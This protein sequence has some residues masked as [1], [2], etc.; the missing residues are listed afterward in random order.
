MTGYDRRLKHPSWVS[1]SL[2]FHIA[3]LICYMI[4]QTAQHLTAQNLRRTP[5]NEPPALPAPGAP[6]TPPSPGR[7]TNASP[8]LPVPAAGQDPPAV[9]TTPTAVSPVSQPAKSGG[10]RLR[11]TFK[12]DQGIVEQFR[13]KLAD[14][15]DSGYDRGHMV[16]SFG[17]NASLRTQEFCRCQL[18]MREEIR[19]GLLTFLSNIS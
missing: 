7:P 16:S 4:V 11:S 14:Y 17:V 9:I 2:D 5:S 19:C 12:E 13:A 15:V 1:A 18:P 6:P 8:P 10:D 3:S